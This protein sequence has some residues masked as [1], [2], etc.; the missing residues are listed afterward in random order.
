L[1]TLYAGGGRRYKLPNYSREELYAE[2]GGTIVLDWL[3]RES[4]ASTPTIVVVPGICSHSESHY[5][6]GLAQMSVDHGFRVVIFHARGCASIKT[7]K[8]FTYGD[9]SDLKQ[10]IQHIHKLIPESPLF[11]IGLSLGGNMLCKYVGEAS[12]SEETQY[13]R[14]AMSVSQGYDALK[15][16]NMLKE[17]KFYDRHV[18]S[19]LTGLVNKHADVFKD[20]ID[21]PSILEIKSVQDFDL[22]FTC[23]LN[24][25]EDLQNYYK[26]HSCISLL[27]KISVPIMLLNSLDDPLVPAPLIPYQLPQEN[28]NVLLVTTKTG[29]HISW[30]E[31]W[32]FPNKEHW[33]EKLIMQFFGS[34]L[35]LEKQE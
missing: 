15:G 1:Q 17:A 10:S 18:A 13:L 6:R 19:K 21:V 30:V 27:P 34:I 4:P 25:Y 3:K 16:V 23:K 2:D 11:G 35:Q 24:G 9:T 14:G 29:G 22:Q 12:S 31:G 26:E 7:P 28:S 20:V 32:L 33:H 5:I 8:L